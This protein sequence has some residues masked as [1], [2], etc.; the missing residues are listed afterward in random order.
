MSWNIHKKLNHTCNKCNCDSEYEFCYRSISYR[1]T[2]ICDKCDKDAPKI[3]CKCGN[4]QYTICGCCSDY[5]TNSLTPNIEYHIKLKRNIESVFDLIC[6]CIDCNEIYCEKCIPINYNQCCDDLKHIQYIHFIQIF[7][8]SHDFILMECELCKKHILNSFYR[9]R[10]YRNENKFYHRNSYCKNSNKLMCNDCAVDLQCKYNNEFGC[11]ECCVKNK[12]YTICKICNTDTLTSYNTGC[13]CH[14]CKIAKYDMRHC[15]ICNT[16]NHVTEIIEHCSYK[17]C[18][19]NNYQIN[20]Y[21]CVHMN[22]EK[23]YKNSKIATCSD[24]KQKYCMKHIFAC[25]SCRKTKCI[26]C[27]PELSFDGVKIRKCKSCTKSNSERINNVLNNIIPK[28]ISMKFAAH[29]IA[30]YIR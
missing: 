8:H 24:C 6:K 7:P 23:K 5:K 3:S 20:N 25:R 22:T 29:I 9:D 1:N 18:S 2:S 15:I 30:D 4:R 27:L 13:I 11:K 17:D 21:C 16:R 26:T 14:L 12:Y 28:H 19:I 10:F